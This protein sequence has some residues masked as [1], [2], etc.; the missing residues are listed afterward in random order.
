MTRPKPAMTDALKAAIEGSGLSRYRLA[1]ATGISEASLCHFMQGVASL[2][3]DK[4]DRL[5]AGR[6]GAV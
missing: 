3:L 5:E 2:R 6:H 4:A 1:G